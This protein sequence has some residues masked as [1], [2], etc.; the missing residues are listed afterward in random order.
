[1][2]F[3]NEDE[4]RALTGKEP[5]EALAEIA[6]MARIAVVKTGKRGSLVQQGDTVIEIPPVDATVVDT[7]GAGDL[8][9][10]GFL[11][12]M[13]RGLSLERCGAIGSLLGGNVIEVI[14]AKLDEERWGR[15]LAEAGR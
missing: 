15:I 10:A 12:G 4:A 1:M 13:T 8:Y 9:A 11:Y 14:G 5:R 7:T 3:A 6:S 2:V